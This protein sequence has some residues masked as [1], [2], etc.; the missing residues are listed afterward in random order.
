MTTQIHSETIDVAEPPTP[1]EK[2][3][4]IHLFLRDIAQ[5]LLDGLYDT[6]V[7]EELRAK[8]DYDFSMMN[9]LLSPTEMENAFL[10]GYTGYLLGP[11]E[12]GRVEQCH[13][14]EIPFVLVI[15]DGDD[16]IWATINGEYV[17][18]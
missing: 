14:K 9:C 15:W 12:F 2:T 18:Y 4:T 1:Q 7:T 16:R 13:E 8:V 11:N 10:E 6:L 5:N 3:E 17:D